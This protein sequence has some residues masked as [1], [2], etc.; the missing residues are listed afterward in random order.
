MINVSEV[1]AEQSPGL[2][3]LLPVLISGRGG[4]SYASQTLISARPVPQKTGSHCTTMSLKCKLDDVILPAKDV[5]V[6]IQIKESQ[7]SFD[8]S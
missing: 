3:P 6:R 1:V 5:Q 4:M 2:R 8:T 7:K